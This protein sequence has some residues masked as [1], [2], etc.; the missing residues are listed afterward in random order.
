MRS[1]CITGAFPYHYF[2]VST[3][4]EPGLEGDTGTR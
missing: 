1:R 3:E 2:L 4:S